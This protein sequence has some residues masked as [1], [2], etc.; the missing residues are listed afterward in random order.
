M[1]CGMD[2]RIHSFFYTIGVATTATIFY[3][4]WNNHYPITADRFITDAGWAYCGFEARASRLAQKI[5][6]FLTPLTSILSPGPIPNK[7]IVFY[8]NDNSVKVMGLLD[9]RNLDENWEVEYD[10]GV[11]TL[12]NDEGMSMTRLFT[13]HTGTDLDNVRFSNASL[14]SAVLKSEDKED[15][16]LDV[17]SDNFK[18]TLVVGNELFT[19]EYMKYVFDID[20]PESYTIDLIDNSINQST[21]VTGGLIRIEENKLDICNPT[22]SR[23]SSFEEVEN[24]KRTSFLFGWMNGESEPQSKK[25]D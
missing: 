11:Y 14:L 12:Q 8:K 19:K 5:S 10:Y 18:A 15:V 22:V 16:N 20:L 13:M 23:E 9:F 24:K 6:I 2:T 25:D 7:E 4:F 3:Y 21:L 17:T 1:D